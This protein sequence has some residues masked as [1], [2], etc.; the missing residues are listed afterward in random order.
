[1]ARPKTLWITVSV[2]SSLCVYAQAT[3]SFQGLGDLPG[4]D[5]E[6]LAQDVSAD[7]QVV[8]GG[9]SSANGGEAFRW[10]ASEGMVGL[11]DLPGTSAGFFSSS[12]LGV[13]A[14]GST[15]V[16]VGKGVSASPLFFPAQNAFRWT[17]AEGMVQIGTKVATSVS[18]DGSVVV[19]Y[20][21]LFQNFDDEAFRWTAETGMEIIAPLRS[22]AEATSADGSVVVGWTNLT[23]EVSLNNVSPFRWTEN[24]GF[25]V[26]QGGGFMQATA[27]SADGSVIVGEN[28][29]GNVFGTPRAVRWDQE[30]SIHLLGLNGIALDVSGDGS[31]IVGYDTGDAAFIWDALNGHRSLL[32]LLEDD[33]GLDLTGWTLTA[34]TGVSNDGLT[35]VGSGVNPDGLTEGW[36]AVIP[37]PGTCGLLFGAIGL[38]LTVRRREF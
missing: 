10:N 33:H 1:M 26:L 3:P 11:G 37:E 23:G 18:A 38:H 30:D 4:G 31:V 24:E 6:S 2:V 16:G 19:G 20:K 12:A 9:S 35:I 36:I 13:S 17:A 25:T 34:A 27:I 29:S 14:D 5:F 15:I 7:G 32:S 21:G 22:F 28:R 8:V